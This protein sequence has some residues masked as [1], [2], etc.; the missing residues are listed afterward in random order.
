MATR[1]YFLIELIFD[2]SLAALCLLSVTVFATYEPF[3]T[4]SII[5]GVRE[6]CEACARKDS[7]GKCSDA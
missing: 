6:V 5:R 3:F 2:G 7:S 1:N 4:Y